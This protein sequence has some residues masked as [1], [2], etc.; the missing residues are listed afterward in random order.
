[1]P[2]LDT[3]NYLE[4]LQLTLVTE[5]KKNSLIFFLSEVL[6]AIYMAYYTQIT[7][8]NVN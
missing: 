8:D 3:I 2:D 1:M 7:F 5:V 6:Q 4:F